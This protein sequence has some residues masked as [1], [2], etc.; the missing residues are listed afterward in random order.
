MLFFSSQSALSVIAAAATAYDDKYDD[1]AAIVAAKASFA[2]KAVIAK[3][4]AAAEK[5]N[6]DPAAV[7][8]APAESALTSHYLFLQSD[9]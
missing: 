1:P 4:S 5:Q 7:I 3:T 6:D 8:A 2:A 9:I